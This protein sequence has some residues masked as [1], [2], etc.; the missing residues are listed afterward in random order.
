MATEGTDNQKI[1][2][3]TV[4]IGLQPRDGPKKPDEKEKTINIK[5]NAIAKLLEAQKPSLVFLQE[6][7]QTDE[8][9]ANFGYLFK[10]EASLLY[11]KFKLSL[12]EIT[13]RNAFEEIKQKMSEGDVTN[14]SYKPRFCVATARPLQDQNAKFLCVSWHGPIKLVDKERALGYMLSY[15]DA[16]CIERNLPCIIGGDFNLSCE[17]VISYLKNAK[18]DAK[19]SCSKYKALPR[20]KHKDVI[21]FFVTSKSLKVTD[22]TAVAWNSLENIEENLDDYF[23]HDPIVGSLLENFIKS[24]EYED[25]QGSGEDEDSQGSGEDEDSQDSDKDEVA[26]LFNEMKL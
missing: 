18:L 24:Y 9:P 16:K 8:I 6:S 3:M 26:D 17:N 10:K 23:D 19:Y 11:D 20:R 12:I 14:G 1:V 25:N 21:D 15:V 5:N 4:N 7:R 2:V 13:D 22:V